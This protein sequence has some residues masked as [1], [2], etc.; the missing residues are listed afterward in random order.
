V[1]RAE[2]A[3]GLVP[4]P[5]AESVLPPGRRCCRWGQQPTLYKATWKR[6]TRIL[7][8]NTEYATMLWAPNEGGGYPYEGGRPGTRAAACPRPPALWARVASAAPGPPC[9]PAALL[10]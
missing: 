8:D 10:T 3:L 1:L 5:V 4:W 7:R 9:A 6:F 2:A